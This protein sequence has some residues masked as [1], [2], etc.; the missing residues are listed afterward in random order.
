MLPFAVGVA[1]GERP[2][3]A[4]VVG[5][6]LAIAGVV[7]V[8]REPSGVRLQRATV[9]LGLLSAAGFGLYLVFMDRAAEHGVAWPVLISRGASG[10]LA[11]IAAVLLH[12]TLTPSRSLLPA[13]AL[14]GV[15]DVTASLLFA[16]ATSHGLLSVVSVLASLYPV[17]T[18]VLAHALLHERLAKVQRV[19]A[20][21]ALGGAAL[22]AA[23]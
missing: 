2:A 11:A 16:L 19:G 14:V 6:A 13:I 1:Q 18:I 21:S 7:L 5:V 4:Q 23:G 17:V 9:A 20:A 12:A 8:S 3:L 10:I 15:L 22:I